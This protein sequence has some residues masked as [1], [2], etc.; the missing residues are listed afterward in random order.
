MRVHGAYVSEK[1]VM[2]ITQF[3]RDQRKPDYSFFQNITIFEDKV[4]ESDNDDERDDIYQKVIEFASS[5]GEISISGIQRRFKI[6]YNRAARIMELLE[7]DGLVGP[8]RGAGK[9]RDFFGKR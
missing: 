9:P 5:A 8:P 7:E 6:G 1:E 3:I 4:I 2:E